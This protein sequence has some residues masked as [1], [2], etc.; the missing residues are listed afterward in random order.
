VVGWDA[1]RLAMLLAVLEARCGIKLSG[2]DVYLNVAGGLRVGEPAA[3]L[4]VAAALVSALS[5][6]ALDTDCVYFG[7]VSL[8]GAIR[9]VRLPDTRLREAAKL[10]FS[11]AIVPASGEFADA[12]CGLRVERIGHLNALAAHLSGAEESARLTTA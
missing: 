1:N 11:A 10:G 2:H 6:V 9:P 7:E 12:A 3:D 4:A 5:G 8:S